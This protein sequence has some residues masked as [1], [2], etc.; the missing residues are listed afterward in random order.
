MSRTLSAAA[1]RSI[2]AAE[3][4][5]YPILLVT[6]DHDDLAEP[7][8]I[9]SDPTERVEETEEEIRYGTIS[10]GTTF[11]FVP[12]SITLPNMASDAAPRSKVMIENV[13]RVLTPI[14]RDLS[15]SPTILME[16]VWSSSVDVVEIE[17]PGFEFVEIE[18]DDLAA[19]GEIDVDHQIAEPF[20]CGVFGPSEFP[21]AF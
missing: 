2:F 10:R 8:Y 6:L 12:F 16:L 15:T 18:Y 19:T 21:G 5:D 9:S 7:Y 1:L 11:Y 17:Y 4:D 14:I 3:T 20:P 13:K